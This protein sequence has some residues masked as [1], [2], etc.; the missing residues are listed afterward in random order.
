MKVNG[1]IHDVTVQRD[2]GALVANSYEAN[3]PLDLGQALLYS[4][5]VSM[6]LAST[7]GSKR[8]TNKSKLYN[9][10]DLVCPRVSLF[11]DRTKKYV[12]YDLAAIL[13]G[14]TAT[15]NT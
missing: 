7:D 2:V 1:K 5:S 11:P 12:I 8:K 4:L 3:C 6:S 9:V 13:C 15:P 14:T 10:I